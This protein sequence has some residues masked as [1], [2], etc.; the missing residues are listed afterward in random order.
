NIHSKISPRNIPEVRRIRYDGG[1]NK[2]DSENAITWLVKV[3]KGQVTP[4]L[5]VITPIVQ[6]S[7]RVSFGTSSNA[8]YNY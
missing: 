5:P 8:N 7:E 6:N 4:D 1:G 3:Q 2:N